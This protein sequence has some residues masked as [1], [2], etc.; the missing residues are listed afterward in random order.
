ML[1]GMVAPTDGYATVCGKDI[2]TQL[3]QIRG[4]I[5]ICLQHDC[6][7]PLLTVKE[8]IQFFAR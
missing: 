4:E 5:G 8:H 1:T 3:G 6:L 2:R 7:F